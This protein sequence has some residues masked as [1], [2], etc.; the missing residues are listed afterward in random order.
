M[1]KMFKLFTNFWGFAL[2]TYTSPYFHK[3]VKF[4]ILFS[5]SY[6]QGTTFQ[7]FFL[8]IYPNL[9]VKRCPAKKLWHKHFLFL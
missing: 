5:I 4:W 6:H 1:R 8:T 2:Q 3:N 9:S 7:C